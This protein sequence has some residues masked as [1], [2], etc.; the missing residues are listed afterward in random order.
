METIDGMRKPINIWYELGSPWKL[1]SLGNLCK[2]VYL[3]RTPKGL[4]RNGVI[5]A[6]AGGGVTPPKEGQY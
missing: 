4:Y 5:L 1:Y 2:L 3:A 6:A